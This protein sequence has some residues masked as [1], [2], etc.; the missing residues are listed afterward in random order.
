MGHH[1]EGIKLKIVAVPRARGRVGALIARNE[2]THARYVQMQNEIG[3][4]KARQASDKSK[5]KNKKSVVRLKKILDR[6]RKIDRNQNKPSSNPVINRDNLVE[7]L[8]KFMPK[9][10]AATG[11]DHL[12]DIILNN[13][14]GGKETHLRTILRYL[15]LINIALSPRPPEEAH[16]HILKRDNN[17]QNGEMVLG[18]IKSVM[19][20]GSNHTP[21]EWKGL[22]IMG[23]DSVTAFVHDIKTTIHAQDLHLLWMR[24]FL[25][26]HF[27]KYQ[28][29]DL[30]TEV[31]VLKHF[32]RKTKK[33]HRRPP[34]IPAS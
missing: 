22:W 18:F 19:A 7:A 31:D 6:L 17:N 9:Y 23:L 11:T 1:E 21:N 16:N 13:L 14:I 8:Q 34:P 26:M 15:A 5:K 29:V 33:K 27:D 2:Q 32:A 30:K 4:L 28:T 10:G 12:Y 24:R 20:N 3:N 25:R